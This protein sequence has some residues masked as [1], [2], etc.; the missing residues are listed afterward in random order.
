MKALITGSTSLVGIEIAKILAKNNIDLVLHYHNK[1]DKVLELK[2]E[3][4]SLVNVETVKCDLSKKEELNKLTKYDVDILINN[5]ALDKPDLFDNKNIDDFKEILDVNLIA[6]FYLS[7][8][9]G[10]K[11]YDKKYGKIINIS[12]T[13]GID[14][15]FPMCLDYDSSKAG[16]ISLT[17]NLSLQ[18][19]PYVNVNSIAPGTLDTEQ[20]DDEFKRQEEE[21]IYKER[22]GKPIE[23]AY[24]VE[25][26]IS[27]KADYINNQVI[28]IDG[29]LY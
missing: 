6:P 13:N 27:D 19:K 7:K 1:E 18:F 14:T 9:L 3:L 15:Y 24:L 21:K 20:L 10:K 29:G 25:F 23:V 4:E 2:K 8:E 5:A 16:L 28:R 11:M 26:L 12:S 17:H 22:F